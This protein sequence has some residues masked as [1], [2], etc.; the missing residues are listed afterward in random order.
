NR[1]ARRMNKTVGIVPDKM[2]AG[3]LCYDWPGNVRELQ[4]VM[5]RAVILYSRGEWRFPLDDVKLLTHTRA[6]QHRT[7]ADAERQHIIDALRGCRGVV[8]GRNG[9]AVRLGLPRT[10]LMAKMT[11][12]GINLCDSELPFERADPPIR[13]RFPG[14]IET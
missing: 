3:L 14:A 10:T 4:N 7:L 5:E 12:L 8:G 11:R 1:A 6:E 2:L 13:Y 9:A